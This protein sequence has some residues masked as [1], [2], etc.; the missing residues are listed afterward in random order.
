MFELPLLTVAMCDVTGYLLMTPPP[1]NLTTLLLRAEEAA[2]IVC[3]GGLLIQFVVGG[4]LQPLFGWRL[5]AS[6][7]CGQ[8]PQYVV[9]RGLQPQFV[10]G[11]GG[12]HPQFCC[13]VADS[14]HQQK[15]VNTSVIDA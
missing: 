5:T 7:C 2:A 10:V 4:G 8:Q 11:C 9:D 15:V 14:A 6:V 1:V 3:C 12:L 13:T